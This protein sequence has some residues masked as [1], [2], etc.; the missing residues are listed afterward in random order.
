MFLVL[1]VLWNTVSPPGL[2]IWNSAQGASIRQDGVNFVNTWDF[3]LLMLY[4]GLHL[5]VILLTYLLRSHPVLFVGGLL[6]I[7]ILAVISVPLSNS[8][9]SLTQTVALSTAN[10]TLPIT[11]FILLHFPKLEVIWAFLS[12]IAGLAFS[13]VG[14]E[15]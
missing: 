6:L 9:E 7:P 13:R 2:G 4:I 5:G 8:Y 3:I 15:Y 1:V 12:L 14:L 11:E 10:T